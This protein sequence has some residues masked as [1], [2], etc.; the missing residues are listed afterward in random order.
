MVTMPGALA[1]TARGR[2]RD[3]SAT[4]PQALA[5]VI[6]KVRR[7]GC[8]AFA[9]LRGGFLSLIKGK[10]IARRHELY[11]EGKRTNITVLTGQLVDAAFDCCALLP[12]LIIKGLMCGTGYDSGLIPHK[13]F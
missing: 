4:A 2:C 6:R 12:L 1:N 10:W 9:L 13:H 7:L 5:A 8:I 3:E 11:A